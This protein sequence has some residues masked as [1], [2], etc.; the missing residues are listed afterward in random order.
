MEELVLAVVQQGEELHR[1][2]DAHHAGVLAVLD[3][4]GDEDPYRTAEHVITVVRGYLEDLA[5]RFGDLVGPAVD[6]DKAL[7]RFRAAG[8]QL[9]DAHLQ[10][11]GQSFQFRYGGIT[12]DAGEQ[13]ADR[14]SHAVSD[15]GESQALGAGDL[16]QVLFNVGHDLDVFWTQDKIK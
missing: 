13:V 11:I 1:L 3:G 12:L 14:G 6:D 9:G 10:G 15:V 8:Q 5:G 2:K 16:P 4:L 7:G